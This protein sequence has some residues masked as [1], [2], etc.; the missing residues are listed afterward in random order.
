MAQPAAPVSSTT[1]M[2]RSGVRPETAIQVFQLLAHEN[3]GSIA[4]RLRARKL[5][6]GMVGLVRPVVEV[7]E[8]ASHGPGNAV[9]SRIVAEHPDADLASPAA[10]RLPRLPRLR[11][12]GIPMVR[13]V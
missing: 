4:G 12:T 10:P 2:D 1:R 9:R 13:L 6:A 8:V 11:S 5:G 3:H 7:E